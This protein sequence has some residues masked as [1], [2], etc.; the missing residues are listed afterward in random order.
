V[1]VVGVSV[2]P[3]G[4]TL[5]AVRAWLRM[6]REPNNFHYLIGSERSLK[7]TW[8]AYFVAPQIPG[9]P[10][11]SHTAAIWLV[12]R[13]G[14]RVAEINAGAPISPSDLAYDFRALLHER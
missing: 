7:P 3:R 13:E 5:A 4:D 10:N 11:S 9:D 6:H 1:A 12:D 8:N 2:D 14:R